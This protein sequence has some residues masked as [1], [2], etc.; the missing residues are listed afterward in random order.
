MRFSLK[1]VIFIFLS[2][3]VQRSTFSAD[4][5]FYVRKSNEQV[6]TLSML[7]GETD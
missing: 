7:G 1:R 2:E 5:L 6:E 3:K 4:L